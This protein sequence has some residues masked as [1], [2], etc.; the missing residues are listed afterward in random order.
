M[1]EENNL[2][3]LKELGK[4]FLFVGLIPILTILILYS[5]VENFIRVF[6]RK[7]NVR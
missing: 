2:D 6:F 5:M 4:W 7:Q 3:K 1:L